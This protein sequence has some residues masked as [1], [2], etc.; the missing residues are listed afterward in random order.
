MGRRCTTPA[1]PSRAELAELRRA[2]REAERKER[3][4]SRERR[5]QEREQ[6]KEELLAARE[7]ARSQRELERDKE[8]QERAA[9]RLAKQHALQAEEAARLAPPPLVVFKRS[10]DGQVTVLSPRPVEGEAAAAAPA[11]AQPNA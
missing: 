2:Q 4:L 5:R 8:R 6:L 10:R 1:G 7:A 9:A 3:E 11:Q